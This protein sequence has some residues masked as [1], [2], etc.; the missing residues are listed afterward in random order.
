VLAEVLHGK[1]LISVVENPDPEQM[2]VVRHAAK[3]RATKRVSKHGM[4]EQFAES[5]VEDRLQPTRFAIMDGHCPM[6]ARSTS[7]VFGRQA[8]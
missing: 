6:D 7:V 5:V 2:N 4:R 8:F 3:D 1:A